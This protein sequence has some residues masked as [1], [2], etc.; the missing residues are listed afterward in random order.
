MKCLLGPQ[1]FVQLIDATCT[2]YTFFIGD[3]LM[4]STVVFWEGLI[5]SKKLIAEYLAAL[6]LCNTFNIE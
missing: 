3:G 5:Q 4:E 6:C 2:G 1:I